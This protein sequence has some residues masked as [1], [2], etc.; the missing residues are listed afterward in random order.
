MALNRITGL[1]MVVLGSSMLLALACDSG[2]TTA[3]PGNSSAGG[4]S[5]QN[6]GTGPSNATGGAPVTGNGT[7][8]ASVIS[9]STGGA[10]PTSTT[11]GSGTTTTQPAAC[12]SLTPPTGTGTLG[13]SSGYVTAGS[14]K[15][16]GFTWVGDKS[17][18]DSTCVTPTCGDTGCKPAFGATSLCAAGVV[19]ADPDYNS[20]VGIGFNLNQASSG[21]NTPGTVPA[22]SSVTV[23][24]TLGSGTGD[25]AARIQLSVLEGTTEVPYCAEAGSW[26]SNTAIDITSFNT[27]CWDNSGTALAAGAN[28]VAVHIVVPSNA[29]A[30]NDFSICLTDFA[31]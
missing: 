12:Q 31:M 17:L 20:I 26:T 2:G 14:Y 29:T 10:K 23:G 9:G 18:K 11:G 27:A 7:G 4:S 15:G 24:A 21:A 13:V 6:T 25:A 1:G 3:S 28:I 8:G 16:Y 22:G 19:A 30:A 5:S